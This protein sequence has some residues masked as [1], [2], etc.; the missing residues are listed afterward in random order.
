MSST[1]GS[2]GNGVLGDEGVG[3]SATGS[4]GNGVT[5]AAGVGANV[6]FVSTVSTLS[7]LV[8]VGLGVESTINE[9]FMERK[10]YLNHLNH[11]MIGHLL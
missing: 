2:V 4:V 11:L 10:L 6:M 7:V 5:G 9:S 3:T 1:T 8:T